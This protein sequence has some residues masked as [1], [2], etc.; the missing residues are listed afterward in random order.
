MAI[1]GDFV[2]AT[3]STRRRAL[4]HGVLQ[5]G[6]PSGRQP[7]AFVSSEG[8]VELETGFEPATFCLGSPDLVSVVA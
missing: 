5:A 1:T 4:W 6:E 7:G 3:D 2:M 8:E